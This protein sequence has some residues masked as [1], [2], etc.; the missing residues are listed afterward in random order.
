MEKIK[1]GYILNGDSFKI[2][3]EL[4]VEVDHI[5]TDPPYNISKENNLHTMKGVRQGIDFGEWDKEFDLTGWIKDAVKLV[6]QGGNIIIF[7][8]WKN[9][10]DIA[11]ALEENGCEVKDLLRWVKSNPMP[12]NRDRRYITDFEFIIWAV[13][14]PKGKNK[15]VFNRESE[16]YQRPEFNYPLT[17]KSERFNHTTPK[18][19]KLLEEIIRIHTNEN[20]IILDPFAGAGSTLLAAQNL[21]RKFLGIELDKDYYNTIINR[22][23]ED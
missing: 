17:P 19:V 5:I 9:M 21:N 16:G 15:W 13:K 8:D 6:K 23:K 2:L 14:E 4:K 12:S 7:N 1:N 22:L 18:P 11:K 10:G 20:D 3:K